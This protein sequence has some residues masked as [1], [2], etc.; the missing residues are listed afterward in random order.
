MENYGVC[1]YYPTVGPPT[2][3]WDINGGTLKSLEVQFYAESNPSKIV[4][5]KATATELP[6]KGFQVKASIW[7]GILLLPGTG[8]GKVIWKA[9][10][11]KQNN[12]KG[13]SSTRTF[14]VAAPEAVG[15][16]NIDPKSKVLL[17]TLSWMNNCNSKF[18]V[19][20]YNDADYYNTPTKAGV[21]KTSLSFTD[22]NPNDNSGAFTKGLTSGQWTSIQNVVGKASG[23]KIYW[24]VESSD[25]VSTSRIAKTARQEFDLED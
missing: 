14:F 11:T 2:F 19:W 12:K 22:T 5:V 16:P 3:R 13:E 8:G 9:V 7:K 25:V 10:G 21:K 4:K 24:H 18:K 1:S 17:P 6:Q 23:A 15:N 20:F